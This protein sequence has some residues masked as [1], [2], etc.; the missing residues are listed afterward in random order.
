MAI[1]VSCSGRKEL[2]AGAL[3]MEE[4]LEL[5]CERDPGMWWPAREGLRWER[6]SS[7]DAVYL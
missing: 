7:N 1:L 2:S 5:C 3:F 6:S 4:P